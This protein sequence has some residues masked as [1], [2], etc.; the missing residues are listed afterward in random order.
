MTERSYRGVA[1]G[2]SVQSN[3]DVWMVQNF[4]R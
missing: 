4:F 3:G 2:F 1:C